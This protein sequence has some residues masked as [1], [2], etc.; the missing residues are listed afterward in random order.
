MGRLSIEIGRRRFLATLIIRILGNRT[1]DTKFL[2]E[3]AID[4]LYRLTSLAHIIDIRF[5]PCTIVSRTTCLLVVFSQ[6]VGLPTDTRCHLLLN[7]LFLHLEGDLRTHLLHYLLIG[8]GH[9][10][11]CRFFSQH[12]REIL[13]IFLIEVTNG[14]MTLTG[15][16]PCFINGFPEAVETGIGNGRLAIEVRHRSIEALHPLRSLLCLTDNI[17]NDHGQGGKQGD[18]NTDNISLLCHIQGLPCSYESIGAKCG[19]YSVLSHQTYRT[20]HT[21]NS[22]C[23]TLE[24]QTGE[25]GR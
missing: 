14:S 22:C 11:G 21:S 24:H 9:I 2:G 3:F 4:F 12:L 20:C 8:V 1:I 10:F 17:G 18:Y 13:T 16:L 6:S 15:A 25:D 23:N 7:V 19:N 5:Q